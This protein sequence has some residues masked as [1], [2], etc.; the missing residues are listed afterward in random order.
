[1]K[2]VIVRRGQIEVADLS[3][4]QVEKGSVLVAVENSLISAGTE[5]AATGEKSLAGKIESAVA[6]A[7]KSIQHLKLFGVRRTYLKVQEKLS[8]VTPLGYSCAGTVLAVGEGVDGFR[9]GDRVACGGAGQANHAEVVS[10]PNNLV[11]P[12]P[13]GLDSRQACSVTVGAI[14]MQGVRRAD[15]RL[16]ETIVVIGLG[17]IGQITVQLL[18]AAGCYVIGT[19]LST[20][21]AAKATSFGADVAVAAGAADVETAVRERTGGHGADATIV[22]AATRS[23]APVQQ[24]M[25]LTRRK[26]RVVVVGD[27]GLDLQR[28]PFYQKEIDFLIS[29]SYGPGR[30]DPQ[31]EAKGLDYPYAYVRWTERRNMDLYL[32]MLAEGRLRFE[33]M[34]EAEYP[35]A[36]ADNA[37]AALADEQKRPLAVVLN[38]PDA[39]TQ[40]PPPAPKRKT[41][42][43]AA[44][45]PLKA[46]LGVGLIGAGEFARLVHLPNLKSRKDLFSLRCC[47]TQYA[48]EA[49]QVSA[50]FNVPKTTTSA[51]EVLADDGVDLVFILT[52]HN[53]HAGLAESGLRTGKAVF[54]E[55][56]MAM[57]LEELESLKKALEETGSPYVVDFNR[58]MAPSARALKQLVAQRSTP[59]VIQY[60]VNAGYLPPDHW[61]QTE[62]GG[63]RLIGEACHMID[64]FLFLTGSR[65]AEAGVEGVGFPAESP[66]IPTDNFAATLRFES[67]DLATL[68]YVSTGSTGAGKERVEVFWDDQTAVLDDYRVLRHYGP[69][70]VRNLCKSREPD[71]GHREMLEAFAHHIVDGGP[72]PITLE[73]MV[74]TTELAC[75]LD[76]ALRTG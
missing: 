1:M 6:K 58:R 15:P 53:L 23:S 9:P 2:Q 39:P 24:A 59:L 69:A 3:P 7:N 22:T 57:N 64:F 65:I 41:A 36:Q 73:E 31:Y 11:V 40:S 43:P 62:E 76:R 4:P 26:G 47:A 44:R 46:P 5:M 34:I 50:L 14:A 52:R 25:E 68:T 56:P 75:R 72:P 63:G 66:R 12:I 51:D 37:Y 19:D 60:R 8:E 18:K 48:P 67:G 45:K 28:L 17:L 29:C 54:C 16:G 49:E 38:Y 42:S 21:R 55:K 74:E 20:H 30:Y 33:E 10:V 71:K 13:H 35:I 27:V 61:T 32:R 70:G